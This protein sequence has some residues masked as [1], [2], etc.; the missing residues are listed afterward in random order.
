MHPSSLFSSAC[1]H[2]RVRKRFISPGLGVAAE[3]KQAEAFCHRI[4]GSPSRAPS[5]FFA[6]RRACLTPGSLRTYSS[7]TQTRVEPGN[8]RP[9]SPLSIILARE[10]LC[11]SILGEHSVNIRVTPGLL[12]LQTDHRLRVHATQS[13]CKSLQQP[14][15]HAPHTI[16]HIARS[17]FRYTSHTSTEDI[18]RESEGSNQKRRRRVGH[19]GLWVAYAVCLSYLVNSTSAP[20]VP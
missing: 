13:Q 5:W 12:Q 9:L 11:S 2:I 10:N 20:R 6:L 15:L 7:R 17:V 14:H 19:R 3:G 18:T 8:S 4:S 16:F 1:S